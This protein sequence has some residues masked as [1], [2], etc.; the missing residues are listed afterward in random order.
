M[1]Q[2]P[3]LGPALRTARR[4]GRG[5]REQLENLRDRQVREVVAHAYTNVPFYRRL[6]DEH[7]AVPSRVRGVGDLHLLPRTS[8]VDLQNTPTSDRVAEGTD[9]S[10]LRARRTTGTTGQP[11]AVFRTRAESRL[12]RLYYFQAFRSLGIHPRDL[13]AGLRLPRPGEPR[14]QY[15]LFRRLANRV[16]LYPRID[17]FVENAAEALGEFKRLRPAVIGSVPGRLSLFAASWSDADREFVRH[18]PWPR[19][20]VT[21]GEKLSPSVRSHLSDAFAA[22]VLDMYST[23]EFNLIASE[24]VKTGLYHVSDETV[25][26]EILDGDRAVEPG[27]TGSPVVTALHSFAA[28]LIRYELSDVI[29]KGNPACE[30]GACLSTI[31]SV[32]GRSMNYFTLP[33]GSVFH[34][35]KILEAIAVSAPWVR[36]SQLS[37]PL[38]DLLVVRAAPLTASVPDPAKLRLYLEKFLGE[39]VKIDVIIDSSLGPA[40]GEKFHSSMK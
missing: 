11:L 38:P 4:P 7:G 26:L 19:L 16:S 28:P 12:L 14:K 8:K 40:D 10:K 18:A 32:D 36:Q 3:P 34:D 9:A 6:Y 2:L 35:A 17:L 37:Q 25:A 33:D 1:G 13:A 24:C 5:A 15:S 22:C 29:T 23:V 39:R 20:I 30:C 27:E 21:G 31:K